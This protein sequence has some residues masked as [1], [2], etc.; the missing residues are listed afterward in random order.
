MALT[1]KQCYPLRVS[2]L[3]TAEEQRWE[4]GFTAWS[5]G[6]REEA[7]LVWR[8]MVYEGRP[9]L[10]YRWGKWEVGAQEAYRIF[11][12]SAPAAIGGERRFWICH[13]GRRV[14]V[15]YCPEGN[16]DHPDYAAVFACRHCY[17]LRYA[18]QS[19]RKH[20]LERILELERELVD[21]TLSWRRLLEIEGQLEPLQQVLDAQLDWARRLNE[22]WE[23]QQNAPPRR[24][25]RPSPKRDRA[26]ARAAK[27]S[28]RA[29]RPKLPPGRPKEKRAYVRHKPIVLS[30]RTSEQ[31]AYC[32]KCRDR[33]DMVRGKP[34]T[35]ENGRSAIQ[36]KC[37]ICKTRMARIIASS[38]RKGVPRAA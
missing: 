30:E 20:P 34:V 2:I 12:E 35:F 37:A 7:R 3:R 33:R 9:A 13:C 10:L 18:S 5:V 1:T 23:A 28:E 22:K 24:R 25:G 19:K 8:P 15:V 11:Y 27:A 14:T 32:P 38:E 31:Q 4:S 17:R 29:A 16:V 36:G 6:S 26:D 21:P